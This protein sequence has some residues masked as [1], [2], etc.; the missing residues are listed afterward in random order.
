MPIR[1]AMLA[2][3]LVLCSP[4][5]SQQAAPVLQGAFTASAGPA[6]YRGKWSARVFTRTPNT[7]AGS[8]I[9]LNDK[10]DIVLQGT[11]SAQKSSAAWKGTWRARVLNG[12]AFSGTWTATDPGPGSKTFAAMLQAAIQGAVAGTWARGGYGGDWRLVPAP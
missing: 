8:W 6:A 2:A 4:A 10:N 12:R 5:E 7:A 3:V 11:W 9:L 1:I